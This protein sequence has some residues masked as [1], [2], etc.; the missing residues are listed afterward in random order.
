MHDDP[1]ET[2]IPSCSK[3]LQVRESSGSKSEVGANE[4]T[5]N[6]GS[7]VQCVKGATPPKSSTSITVSKPLSGPNHSIK[8]ASVTAKSATPRTPSNPLPSSPAQS[9]KSAM[10]PARSSTSIAHSE[11]LPGSKRSSAAS[12]N[13]E[14][15]D[16]E[17]FGKDEDSFEDFKL[18]VIKLCHDIGYGEPAEVERME[19]G[20]YNKIIGLRFTSPD[21]QKLI[22]RMPFF[23]YEDSH[24]YEISDQVSVLLYLSQFDFMKVPQIL[25]YDTTGNNA[26]GTQFV[27]QTR[28]PGSC[29][30]D[31]FYK[32]TLP[33]KLHLTGLVAEMAMKMMEV[34]LPKPGR[35]IGPR[36][37]PPFS[38]TPPEPSTSIEIGGYR[39]YP[40]TDPPAIEQQ[41]LTPFLL[42]LLELRI[43]DESS[44]GVPEMYQKLQ[45]ITREMQM[46]GLMREYDVESV[47][48]H[49]DFCARN[50]LIQ[51][52]DFLD[53]GVG[54]QLQLTEPRQADGIGLDTSRS[55]NTTE[56]RQATDCH[57]SFQIAVEEGSG[58][59]HKHTVQVE[60]E[61]APGTTC[62]HNVS[63]IVE[64]NGQTYRHQLE[65]I[66][67]QS[68][69]Q[70]LQR[71][72][73]GTATQ[74]LPGEDLKDRP[75]PVCGT[76]Q[77]VISGVLD[78][79][80]V[81]AVP[82]VIARRPHSW[83]WFDEEERN[84][85]W[86]GNE[87]DKPHRDLTEDE[88]LIKG[89]FDQIMS[90]GSPDYLEDAYN[91]GVW[92]RQLTRFARDGFCDSADWKR[93]KQ[94]IV[95]WEEH[96]A[97]LG[98]KTNEEVDD[99]KTDR[100]SEGEESDGEES[101][102]EESGRG[103]SDGE[104]DGG[105]SDGEKSKNGSGGEES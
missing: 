101:D 85:D 60:I 2:H 58:S 3:D 72:I 19:G 22:I 50:I 69:D 56:V 52:Q 46:A 35:L 12:S 59:G 63:V 80:D 32:L 20:S 73:N 23:I 84:D 39:E 81:L 18:K 100:E 75:P 11:P 45:A 36:S 55:T 24:S 7:S 67:K 64:S 96:Y 38:H 82:L 34:K 51:Q 21:E 74:S 88:L 76:K 71:Q 105:V 95:K 86:T 49:W 87:D 92:L 53:V 57:H 30:Q 77:W 42:E 93:Y 83:L 62:K 1:Q 31:V 14:R 16:Y 9:L 17:T 40:S 94:F 103:E 78:W 48:W 25:A 99:I 29:M 44:S 6:P 89:H 27:L 37:L 70:T 47:L 61:G 79:D 8:S 65:I 13:D 104:P 41:H 33:E 28:L 26:I 43:Q 91:R 10:S 4:E 97:S 66:D 98:F 102:G 90:R 15:K 68:S 54:G 5:F